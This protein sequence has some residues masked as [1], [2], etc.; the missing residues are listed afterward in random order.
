VLDG[1]DAV[2]LSAETPPAHIGGSG[3]DD[4]AIVEEV[5]RKRALPGAAEPDAGSG[6]EHLRHRGRPR[7]RAASQQ[8]GIGT[9]CV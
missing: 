7:L 5:E 6:R 8:L 1:T 2:M 4:A 3:E 9:I